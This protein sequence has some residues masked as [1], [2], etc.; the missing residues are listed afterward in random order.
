MKCIH[1]GI[2]Y[3][4]KIIGCYE[5]LEFDHIHTY[6]SGAKQQHWKAKC[7][8]CN[9]IKVLSYTKLIGKYSQGCSQCVK[10]RFSGSNGYNWN[11]KANN[12]PSMYFHKLKRSAEKR[13]LD[14]TISREYIDDLFEKQDRKC[15]YTK[16]DLYFGTNQYRGTASLDRIDSN[17]GYVDGNI[18]WVHKDVNT[19]K[20]DLTHEKFIELCQLIT[21]NYKNARN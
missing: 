20:W 15:A 9:N 6:P 11:S 7:I 4:G 1:K 18:Q 16:Y 2:D 13:N 3:T 17:K 21:E 8:K 5:I 19:I 14:F 12:V 10:E